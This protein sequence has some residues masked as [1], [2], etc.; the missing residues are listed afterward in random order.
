MFASIADG[1][2][3]LPPDN[4]PNHSQLLTEMHYFTFH[5]TLAI[6]GCWPQVRAIECSAHVSGIPEPFPG[7][8][9][10]GH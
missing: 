3:A 9:R 2:V 4:A 6:H 10:N 7:N 8:G 1:A 5:R